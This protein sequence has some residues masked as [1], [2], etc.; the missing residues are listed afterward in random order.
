[1]SILKDDESILNFIRQLK[2]AFVDGQKDKSRTI[3]APVKSVKSLGKTKCTVYDISMGDPNNQVFFANNI[4]VHN[5][6]SCYFSAYPELKDDIESGKI[7]MTKEDFIDL[8]DTIGN[9]VSDTF[10]AFLHTTFNVPVSRS[11]GVIKAG[12]EVVAST[13]LFIKKK[14]YAAMVFDK[15]GFREDTDGKP[16]KVKAMGL[17]LRRSD[18]PK[19]IQSFLKDVLYKTLTGSEE[20]DVLEFIKTFR[21]EF[22]GLHPWKK[23][24]PKAANKI[25][26]YQEKE[27]LALVKRMKGEDAK[28][29]IPGHVRGAMNWNHLRSINNDRVTMPIVDGQKVIVCKLKITADNYMNCIAYPVDEP[30]LPTW[31]T[32]LPF[33]EDEME[34]VLIDKKLSNLLGVLKWDLESTSKNGQQFGSLFDMGAIAEEVEDDDDEEE[35]LEYDDDDF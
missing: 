7:T 2:S 18:T 15:D 33:D 26:I 21:D 29:N 17:D 13:G 19:F 10:P 1:M 5:T 4:L 31:F 8:Y 12:R 14:R 35:E 11:T 6:D 20:T 32:E 9:Q 28:V 34:N 3:E 27:E 16:G 30:R 23:G 22:T 25:S 24:S